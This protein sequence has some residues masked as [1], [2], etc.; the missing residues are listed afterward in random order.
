MDQKYVA[1]EHF[2]DKT[3]RDVFGPF[4]DYKDAFAWVRFHE[5]ES[6]RKCSILKMNFP[7]YLFASPIKVS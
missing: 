6:G 3:V 2:Q 7:R 4:N 1:I 5:R